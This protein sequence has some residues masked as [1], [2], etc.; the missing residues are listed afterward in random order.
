[1]D[2]MIHG[3][4]P[5]DIRRPQ[6]SEELKESIK[7]MRRRIEIKHKNQELDQLEA[8]EK[9]H[10]LRLEEEMQNND[11]AEQM[12]FSNYLFDNVTG[13][14]TDIKSDFRLS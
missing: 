1:M 9:R 6:I 5:I 4:I 10:K 3:N 14:V 7:Y 12:D 13:K 11:N 2:Y 8:E